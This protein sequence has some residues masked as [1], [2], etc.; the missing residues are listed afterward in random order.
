MTLHLITG[1]KDKLREAE[2][3]L[4]MQLVSTHVELVEIQDRDPMKIAEHKVREAWNIVK[5]PVFVWDQ[6]VY[7]D[8]LNDF[9]GPFIKWFW[10]QVTLEKICQIANFYNN[11]KIATETALAYFDGNTVK[12]FTAR[13]EGTMPQAPRGEKGWGWD[14]IFIPQGG[15]KTYAE[16]D[17]EEVLQFR[18]HRVTLEKLKNYL[19]EINVV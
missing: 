11:D 1:N 18:T 2:R 8:C 9:P 7:I 4:G 17:E 14:P 3:I 13:T 19:N 10:E 15:T 16:M 12:I 6:A 5:E